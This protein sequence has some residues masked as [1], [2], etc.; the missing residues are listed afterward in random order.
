MVARASRALGPE[1][2]RIASGAGYL[3]YHPAMESQTRTFEC[4]FCGCVN[5]YEEQECLTRCSHNSHLVRVIDS[6]VEEL[7]FRGSEVA[8]RAREL[9]QNP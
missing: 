1:H 8:V 5:I 7:V 4:P 2:P 6:C 3:G 9:S